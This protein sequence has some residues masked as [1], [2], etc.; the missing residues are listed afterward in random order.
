VV[1]LPGAGEG[2][3]GVDLQG[4][5][6]GVAAAGLVERV[7]GALG[8]GLGHRHRGRGSPVSSG[9]PRFLPDSPGQR[10]GQP[11]TDRGPVPAGP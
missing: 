10:R 4:L 1:A 8:A 6:G 5:A 11:V 9:Q 3:P 2:G 7:T